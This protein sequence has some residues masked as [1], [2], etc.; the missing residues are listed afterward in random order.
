[1]L[2]QVWSF[3]VGLF[4]KTVD[5]KPMLGNER[6]ELI[7]TFVLEADKLVGMNGEQKRQWVRNEL[8]GL[9]E[10]QG[11]TLINWAIEQILLE[12]KING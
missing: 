4:Q 12:L 3:I 7:K 6:Y 10:R 1:M 9:I 5:F 2:K 11:N 8:K